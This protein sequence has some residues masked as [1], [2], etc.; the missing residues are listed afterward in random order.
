LFGTF[1]AAVIANI[2]NG[3]GFHFYKKFTF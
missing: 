2:K 1:V 3:T